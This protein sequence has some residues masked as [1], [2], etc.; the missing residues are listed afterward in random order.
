M[1]QEDKHHF[2]KDFGVLI[3]FQML[4]N[5]TLNKD[6]N[7]EPLLGIYDKT[8]TDSSLGYLA[9]KN[10]R[11]RLTC[12]EEDVQAVLKGSTVKIEGESQTFKVF[13]ISPDGTG[14][15]IIELSK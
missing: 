9:T 3:E 7:G 1:F 5:Q 11:P 13:D 12:V 6:I 4:N 15:S 14:F 2:L 10:D 8:F